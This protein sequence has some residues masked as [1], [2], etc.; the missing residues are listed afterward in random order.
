M[1]ELPFEVWAKIASYIPDY[2][3]LSLCGVNR[4]F[5]EYVMKLRYRDLCLR[6]I[7]DE[8]LYVALS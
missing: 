7:D 2:Q 1:S 8:K 6:G 3:M 4:P 5:F